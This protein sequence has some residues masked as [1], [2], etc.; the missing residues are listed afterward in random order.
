V[1]GRLLNLLSLLDSIANTLRLQELAWAAGVLLS[2]LGLVLWQASRK[3]SRRPRVATRVPVA[4]PA[5]LAAVTPEIR[6][7]VGGL[8][9]LACRASDSDLQS[10]QADP[11]K[12]AFNLRLLVFR[13]RR[14]F[15]ARAQ[16]KA[17]RL[18]TVVADDVPQRVCAD[19]SGI[20]LALENLL[21]NAIKFTDEGVVRLDVVFAIPASDSIPRHS[22]GYSAPILRTSPRD[23]GCSYRNAWLH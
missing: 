21:D 18:K 5:L 3:R 2:L 10:R 4:A 1:Y 8:V 11:A 12:V 22:R 23:T 15:A 7:S 9:A 13:C 16:S 20:L 6:S 19:R 17:L 14:T